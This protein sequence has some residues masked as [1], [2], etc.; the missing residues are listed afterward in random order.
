MSSANNTVSKDSVDEARIERRK[1]FGLKRF[2]VLALYGT[3][4]A[5]IWYYWKSGI[6]S[7]EN[8]LRSIAAYPI[9]APALFIVAYAVIVVFMVPSLPLNIGAGFLWGP[10]LGSLYTLIG[11][12]LGSTLS[13]IF[14]RSTLGQPFAR[15][16]DNNILQWFV[17]QLSC[18]GW[19]VVAFVRMNP[20]FPS[21][22]ANYL[23]GLTSISFKEYFI[24]TLVFPYPLCLAFSYVGESAGGVLLDGDA[25]RAVQLIIAVT[26]T[27]CISV[28]GWLAYKQYSK[29]SLDC[30][31]L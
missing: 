8:L 3:F 19:R 1:I 27:L 10:F 15:R 9:I 29:Q 26:A 4:S 13:F 11:C 17:K 31:D 28:A 7:P 12:T 24:S 22:P 16:F 21:G 30:H 2:F 6:L 14:A 18:N 23:F 5:V 25:K 20:A